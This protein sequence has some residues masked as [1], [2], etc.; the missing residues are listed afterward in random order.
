ML[1]V[2]W[3]PFQSGV[4]DWEKKA[5]FLPKSGAKQLVR[6]KMWEPKLVGGFNP[7]EKYDRQIGFV[8]PNFR[9]ERKKSLSCHHPDK[10]WNT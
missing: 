4:I 9:D 6:L 1:F 8:F 3:L 7:S 5:F 10:Q 2:A